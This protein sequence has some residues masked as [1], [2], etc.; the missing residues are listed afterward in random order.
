MSRTIQLTVRPD[1]VDDALGAIRNLLA[2]G[3]GARGTLVSDVWQH[4]LYPNT[5]FQLLEFTDA[6]A[7]DT[8]ASSRAY[9]Q[10]V[11]A[12]APL[13]LTPPNLEEWAPVR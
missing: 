8:Y 5:F 11:A 3:S 9:E 1:A 4:A 12:L 10:F 2:T 13:C 7:A 6:P